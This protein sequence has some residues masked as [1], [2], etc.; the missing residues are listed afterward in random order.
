[1]ML[2]PFCKSGIGNMS[3]IQQFHSLQ[4]LRTRLETSRK[5]LLSAYPRRLPLLP[6]HAPKIA[7]SLFMLA[8]VAAH[9][10]CPPQPAYPPSPSQG[11]ALEAPE[12][13]LHRDLRA[14]IAA[15]KDGKCQ[16]NKLFQK[17]TLSKEDREELRRVVREHA[18]S[19]P[20]HDAA[21]TQ[22]RH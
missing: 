7:C 9:A 12:R 3:D 15:Q 18:K 22:H 21:D 11:M 10:Q 2:N 1:M 4:Q 8:H 20:G 13:T 5:R 14:S 19:K 16:T 6:Q 17:R